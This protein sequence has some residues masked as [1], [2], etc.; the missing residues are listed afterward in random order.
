M[1]AVARAGML[2][3]KQEP[4]AVLVADMRVQ[5]SFVA[6]VADKQ[7]R[8]LEQVVVVAVF[9]ADK[10]MQVL[11][12][13]VVL[14]PAVDKEGLGLEQV[15]QHVV[16]DK[17]QQELAAELVAGTQAVVLLAA[18]RQ[19]QELELVDMHNPQELLQVVV[20]VPPV[21][22]RQVQ[23]LE[24]ADTRNPQEL[25]QLV[26]ALLVVGTRL[27][28]SALHV[29]VP[30]DDKQRQVLGPVVVAP[31]AADKLELKLDVVVL[32]VADKQ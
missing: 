27:Q 18:D 4:V 17:Q 5:G 32:L 11:E 30:L 3:Q 10:Q 28:Q 24:Q 9:A 25:L 22:D 2:A 1:L 21:A 26:V 14:V 8:V 7:E 15:V 20:V 19:V 16:V 29:A 6:L 23:G 13:A 31:L 12:Q